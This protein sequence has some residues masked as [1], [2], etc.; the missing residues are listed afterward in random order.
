MLTDFRMVVD[1]RW[2]GR[3]ASPF[4]KVRASNPAARRGLQYQNRVERELWRHVHDGK[5]T[6]LEANPWFQFKDI[7]GVANCAPDFLLHSETELTIVE[8]KLTWV[9]VAIHKLNDLYNP[10]VS[11][12]LGRPAFPLIICRNLTRASP[13][14]VHSLG[15]ALKSPYRLLHW[16]DVGHIRW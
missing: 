13:P 6:A 7:Y 16:P 11:T 1:I 12:A 3:S 5:F 14:A 9:E 8:V 2:A 4:T 10:V 15:D